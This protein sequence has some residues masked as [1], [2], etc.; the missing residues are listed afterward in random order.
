MVLGLSYLV[1]FYLYIVSRKEYHSPNILFSKD[2]VLLFFGSASI[3][4]ILS[5]VYGSFAFKEETSLTD[6]YELYRYFYYASFYL[7]AVYFVKDVKSLLKCF[8]ISVFVVELFGVLQFYNLF[9]INN[10]LG[11]LYTQNESFHHMIQNQHRI[12]S[13]FKNPNLYGSF[14]I[15]VISLTLSLIV[16]L[17]E[18]SRSLTLL[19]FALLTLTLLNVFLST[20]RT[21]IITSFGLICYSVFM[22]LVTRKDTFKGLLTKYIIIFCVFVLLAVSF[23][24]S[25]PYLSTAAN[26]IVS[27]FEKYTQ[28]ED[29][30]NN[31]KNRKTKDE[32]DNSS[33][34]ESDEE[35]NTVNKV[36]ESLETVDSFNNR[37]G[38]WEV[39]LNYF[40]KSPI[41]GA[42]P[43]KNGYPLADNAYIYLLA[44]YGVVGFL[45][46]ISFILI[47]YIKTLITIFKKNRST[48]ELV[49]SSTVNIILVA[50]LVIGFVSEVWLNIQSM[51][52]LFILL[53]ILNNKKVHQHFKL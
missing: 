16:L 28:S 4:V 32:K 39:N 24:P 44:R 6:V 43:M 29:S 7:I 12:T 9:N 35:E 38:A 8:I 22:F 1:L 2:K 10:N 53:G 45:I 52:F 17:K 18:K 11:L 50:Y 42:G 19:L 47:I 21:T 15:I 3:S 34:T 41:I 14:L 48:V 46:Y 20:S 13:T 25:I 51:I 30:A 26:S 5:T 27:T 23:V 33:D 37:Y 40:E 31:N 36:K 49:T